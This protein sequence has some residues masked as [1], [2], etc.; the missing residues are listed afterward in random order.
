MPTEEEISF[1]GYEVG[2]FKNKGLFAF[3]NDAGKRI[4]LENQR[5]IEK[6]L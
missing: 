5:L 2:S 1:G 3:T 4:V 6:L